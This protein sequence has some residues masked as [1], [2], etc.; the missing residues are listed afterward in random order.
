MPNPEPIYTAANV[1]FAY[2]LRWAMTLFI[3]GPLPPIESLI[4]IEE[5]LEPDGIRVLSRRY[6]KP[7]ML[8]FTLSTQPHL[9]PATII[10]RSKGRLWYGWK[11]FDNVKSKKQYALR[12]YGTQERAIVEA[13]IAGQA[14]HHPMA[15]TKA[16]DLFDELN[17]INDN[18]N[19]ENPI[20]IERSLVWFNLHIVLVHSERWRTVQRELLLRVQKMVQ[21]VCAKYQWRLS[22]CGILADHLHIALGANLE[23]SVEDIVLKL[24]NNLAYVH[25]MTAVY[26]YSAYVGTFGEYDQ[27]AIQTIEE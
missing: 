22:R 9:S 5:A 7:N 1:K 19:L 16:N 15:T 3:D 25:G 17:L 18:V 23:D 20:K 14:A 4:P 11:S 13:Y 6:V 24:M 26:Q 2:Q 10:Q 12:S 8:Q 27:R 21:S